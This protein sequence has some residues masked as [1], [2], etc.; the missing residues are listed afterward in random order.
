MKPTLKLTGTNGNAFAI[1]GAA[2]KAMRQAG[3]E[4]DVI[5]RMQDEATSGDYD[6]LLVTVMNYCEV[7]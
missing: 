5:H 3:I 2:A 6:H 4:P 7:S 1:L